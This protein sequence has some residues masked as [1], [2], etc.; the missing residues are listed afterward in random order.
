[1]KARWLVMTLLLHS[2]IPAL[3]QLDND[4]ENAQPVHN[5][6]PQTAAARRSA[7]A[8]E[9]RHGGGVAGRRAASQ[10]PD[11]KSDCSDDQSLRDATPAAR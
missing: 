3:A 10:K 2:A 7:V 5:D 8:G 6:T 4:P 1:M 9:C 11:T